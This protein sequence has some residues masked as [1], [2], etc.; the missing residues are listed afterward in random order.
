MNIFDFLTQDEID[1]LP[2]DDPEAAFT[3]FV[4]HAQR[5]LNERTEQLEQENDW[6][7][8][9]EARYGFMNVVIAAGKKF[10][11]EPFATL[12]IPRLEKFSADV[13]RQFKADL[14][15]YLTQL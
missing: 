1:N 15:H 3:S 6:R 14:D 10:E 2:D 11:I 13:H 12:E 8:I 7:L 4:R 5:R 9:E